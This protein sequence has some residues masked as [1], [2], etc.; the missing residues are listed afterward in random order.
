MLAILRMH[1]LDHVIHEEDASSASGGPGASSERNSR[2]VAG[3]ICALVKPELYRR[4][5][6]NERTDPKRTMQLLEKLSCQF[7]FL[8]LPIELRSHIYEMVLTPQYHVIIK[9]LEGKTSQYHAITRTSRQIRQEVLSMF[10]TLSA[11]ELKFCSLNS[12]YEITA[13]AA[14]DI[15]RWIKNVV[16]DNVKRLTTVSL[17]TRINATTLPETLREICFTCKASEGLRITYPEELTQISKQRLD[18]HVGAVKVECE[19]LGIEDKA[20]ILALISNPFLW[21]YSTLQVQ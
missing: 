5:P 8:D 15:R 7:R 1:R 2:S 12:Q 16:Q 11:F 19:L 3:I 14:V 21:I 20:V 10:Y 17:T 6:K 18:Y 9:P 4:V 13:H